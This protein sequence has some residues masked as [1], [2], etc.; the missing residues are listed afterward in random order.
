MSYFS[1]TAVPYIITILVYYFSIVCNIRVPCF[2]FRQNINI[3]SYKKRIFLL[4]ILV[5]FMVFLGIYPTLILD[6]LHYSITN[7]IYYKKNFIHFIHFIPNSKI[8]FLLFYFFL[9]SSISFIF[10]F[11]PPCKKKFFWNKNKWKVESW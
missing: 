10:M 2:N 8:S 9:W 6:D 4:F 7:L 11:C 3:L 5:S 1:L